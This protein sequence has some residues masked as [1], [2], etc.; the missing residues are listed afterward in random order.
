LACAKRSIKGNS[1]QD[2][3]EVLA[4]KKRDWTLPIS[5]GS[6]QDTSL[7]AFKRY[8]VFAKRL[9]SVSPVMRGA[10]EVSPQPS[11]P[12]PSTKRKSK[13]LAF[14][15]VSPDIFIG[16]RSG[17]E[18]GKSVADLMFIASIQVLLCN[19]FH[20]NSKEIIC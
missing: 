8:A 16:A 12:S 17:I 1:T 9:P 20:K 11:L 13:V 2:F 19:Q 18:S 14:V 10:A 7:A 3:A 5:Q 15:T 6:A 4:Y